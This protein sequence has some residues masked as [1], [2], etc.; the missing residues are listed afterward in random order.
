M[1]LDYLG[2]RIW[3]LGL[4]DMV[5]W[6]PRQNDLKLPPEFGQGVPGLGTW[7]PLALTMM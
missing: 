5:S 2:A 1:T 7:C 3:W 6:G 4:W